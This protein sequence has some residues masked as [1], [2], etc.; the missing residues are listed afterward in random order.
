MVISCNFEVQLSGIMVILVFFLTNQFFILSTV[1]SQK[2]LRTKR[3]CKF[4]NGF[5]EVY[6][7]SIHHS[8]SFLFTHPFSFTRTWMLS[9]NFSFEIFF[10]LKIH[11]AGSFIP[12]VIHLSITVKDVHSC[13]VVQ[14]DTVFSPFLLI[15]VLLGRSNHISISFIFPIYFNGYLYCKSC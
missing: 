11:I 7:F 13:P 8:I 3:E 4:L 15:V 1:W 10:S 12:S 5:R 6:T 9:E 2:A 14:I